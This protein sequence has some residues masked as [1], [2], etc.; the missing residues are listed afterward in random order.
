MAD[1]HEYDVSHNRADNDWVRRLGEEIEQQ[2]ID[3]LPGSR[4][5]KVF[6][7]E[8]DIDIGENIIVRLNEGLKN[9]RFVACVLSPEFMASDW[10]TFEWTHV[11]AGDPTN[12]QKRI[13]PLLR[14]DVALNGVD[15]IDLCAPFKG[16]N[17]IDFRKD[18]RYKSS[19][20][21]LI[22]RIRGL[23]PLRG[24]PRP[25]NAMAAVAAEPEEPSEPDSI[26]E[27]ILGNLLPVNFIPPQIFSADT[28]AREIRAAQRD[29]SPFILRNGRLYTFGKLH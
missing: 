5:L 1:L 10:T 16:S 22:R 12:K 24:N 28:T 20:E 23:P 9:S 21:R 4:T 7:D 14:R 25:L 15:Q 26:R 18:D 29:V 8:W 3:G 27:D 17:Y 6:F 13:I 19:F 2:T 11:V